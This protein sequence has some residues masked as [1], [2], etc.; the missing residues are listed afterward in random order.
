M[1]AELP[2]DKTTT[3]MPLQAIAN[4]GNRIMSAI[5]C[6]AFWLGLL[7]SFLVFGW[8]NYNSYTKMYEGSCDDCFVYFGFPFDLYQ[9][10]GYAGGQGMLWLGLMANISI[11]LLTGICFGW[12]LKLFLQRGTA[13]RAATKNQA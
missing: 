12:L 8:A 5:R 2:A 10:G 4:W 1:N 13:T 11:A 3:P 9:G 7:S 6:Q